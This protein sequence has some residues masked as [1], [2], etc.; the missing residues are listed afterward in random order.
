MKRKM[1]ERRTD[2][3]QIAD[4]GT[5]NTFIYERGGKIIYF[6]TIFAKMLLKV[7]GSNPVTAETIFHAPFT[8]IKAW[9]LKV[10]QKINLA[11]LHVL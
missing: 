7:V 4:S 10:G 9:K 11:L 2:R 3:E 6:Q 1:R 5:H 8:W